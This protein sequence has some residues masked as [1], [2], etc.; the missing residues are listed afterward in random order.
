MTRKKNETN[1]QRIKRI[2]ENAESGP[3]MQ[4]FV[5]D[6]LAQHADRVR[7][8]FEENPHWMDGNFINPEAWKA[9]ALEVCK[10]FNL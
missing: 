8:E 1:V 3:L 4:C 5:I 2:M 6:A 10:E 9:C 7:A